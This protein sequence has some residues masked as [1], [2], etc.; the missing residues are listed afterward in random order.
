MTL[1]AGPGELA[2]AIVRALR[3]AVTGHRVTSNPDTTR[4]CPRC[5]RL[6]TA[7]EWGKA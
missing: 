5:R 2:V 4:Y 1:P 3:C 6:W 7:N